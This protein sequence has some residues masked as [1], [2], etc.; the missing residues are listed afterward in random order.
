MFRQPRSRLQRPLPALISAVAVLATVT[1][2]ASA[3]AMADPI[4][5]PTGK[6]V[7]PAA[8]DIV[9][10]ASE[11]TAYTAAQLTDNYDKSVGGKHSPANPYI[12]S[13]DA[14]PTLLPPRLIVVEQ[15]C[16][17]SYR[18]PAQISVLFSYG[19]TSYVYKGKKH[20]VPCIDFVMPSRPRS[21]T[22]PPYAPGG[23]AFDALWQDAVTYATT[24]GSNAPDNLT[25]AQLT[26][27]FGCTVPAAN[28]DPAN[29]W[30]ALLGSKAKQGTAKTKID[31]V[32]PQAGSATLSF[33]ATTA[34]GL[35]STSEPTCGSAASLPVSKQ[36]EE[37]EGVNSIFL[38]AGKPDPNVI[39]PYSIGA[40]LSQAQYSAKCGKKPTK[41]QNMFGCN[42]TASSS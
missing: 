1:A 4:N 8:Y 10:V 24:K 40:Y 34:L 14:A 26:Q 18:P 38:A 29:T 35:V 39:Y 31:P 42:Q 19:T 3:P 20:L 7:T 32:L 37:N 27:I 5:P 22:D 13:W 2:L 36:P 6:V 17:P 11:A 23:V 21:Q 12:Y 9:G 41:T 16:E 28:G 15:G 30:G 33:W 25:K